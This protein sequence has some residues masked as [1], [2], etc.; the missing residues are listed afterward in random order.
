MTTIFRVCSS[1]ALAASL[2]VSAAAAAPK[3]FT[4]AEQGTWATLAKDGTGGFT[5]AWVSYVLNDVFARRYGPG[6]RALT[7]GLSLGAYAYAF[8]TVGIAATGSGT[9]RVAWDVVPK[10][11]GGYLVERLLRPGDSPRGPLRNLGGFATP[12]LAPAGTDGSYAIAML[13][14]FAAAGGPQSGVIAQLRGADGRLRRQ[15]KLGPG[16]APRAASDA[17][18]GFWVVWSSPQG[19]RARRFSSTAEPL[20]SYLVDAAPFPAGI[21][22]NRRG[23]LVVAWSDGTGT[24]ARWWNGRDRFGPRIPVGAVPATGISRLSAAMDAEGKT[25]LVW[26]ACCT[27]V[28]IEARRFEAGGRPAGGVF[29]MRPDAALYPVAAAG[30]AGDFVV[31]W[32][33]AGGIRGQRLPWAR[34]GDE[35]CLVTGG[36][37][38]CDTAH[39]GGRAESEAAFGGTQPGIPLLGDLD[40]DGRD[41]SCLLRDGRLVCDTAHDEGAAELKLPAPLAAGETPL[42]G[43]LDGEGRDDYCRWRANRLECDTSHD[44]AGAEVVVALHTSQSPFLADWD[45][46]GDDDPCAADAGTFACDV[47]HDGNADATLTLRFGR[48]DEMPL[49]GDVNGDGRA[50]PCLYDGE[51]LRCDTEREGDATFAISFPAGGANPASPLLGNPDGI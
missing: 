34:P 33:E 23:E 27:P 30:A 6:D 50:D 47:N 40:G 45:G 16:F 25:L 46:D 17:Q 32:D 42:L 15:I 5:A 29:V 38:R 20:D 18:G 10:Y 26:G 12:S 36:H 7:E 21:A 44:G 19:V 31:A 14:A 35:L 22:G 9:Y 51:E 48:H 43:D 11:Y 1:V 2:G 13:G 37:W 4:I 3:P 41:D 39:D 49:L 8:P 24:H 28:R